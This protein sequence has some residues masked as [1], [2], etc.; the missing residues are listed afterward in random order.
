MT[1]PAPTPEPAAPVTSAPTPAASPAGAGAAASLPK[2]VVRRAN[3]RPD[4]VE[5]VF[6]CAA[7]T[8]IDFIDE[9]SG[10]CRPCWR[11]AVLAPAA[12][13]GRL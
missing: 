13:R 2:F 11:V 3:V 12:L 7:C 1:R 10:M 5:V 4:R 9:A 8:D 6:S